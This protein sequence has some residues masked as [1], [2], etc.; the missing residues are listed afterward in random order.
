MKRLAAFAFACLT[1]CAPAPD[2]TQAPQPTLLVFP[3]MRS[4]GVATPTAPQRPNSEIAGDFLDLAFQME[5]GQALPVLTR[6]KETITVRT[7]GNFPSYMD[8]DLDQLLVRLRNEARIDISRSNAANASIVIE[9]ISPAQMRRAA[10]NAACFVVPRV[11]SWAELQRS[12]RNGALDWT[13]LTQREHAAI[14]IPAGI[15]PQEARD[16][17]HEELAQAL[18]PLNDL[19]RLPDSVYN[20]DNIHAVLTGFDMLI[21]RA[22]Y[23]DQLQNGMTRAQA[24][25]RIPGILARINPAG[26]RGG[27]SVEPATPRSWKSAME[28]ALGGQ[29]SLSSRRAAAARAIDIGGQVGWSGAREGFAYYAYG[30]LQISNDASQALY[31][32]N[33][34]NQAYSQNRI[35]DIHAAHVAVQLAAATL[36]ARDPQT[37][38]RIVD[39]AIPAAQRH[40]N[41]ALLAQLM[42]FKAE[43]LD[44][45]GNTEAGAAL[46]LDS[47]A[48]GRYGFGS[49]DEVIDRLNEI[50]SLTRDNPS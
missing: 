32:F 41:A 48:W 2:A 49:R 40:E 33:A 13:T 47:L 14:F 5:T 28:T 45:Q 37:T 10:P 9:I 4:F 11:Q 20:D 3:Q 34:A 1:A 15:P 50:A 19:Y 42:M 27:G 44:L 22:F 26:Q 31:A 35:M 36:I 16:C 46:R 21:L 30:R 18:G 7:A 43:A 38:I 25:S 29:G 24:A 12:R 39:Q 17:M 23:D 6:F 8:R